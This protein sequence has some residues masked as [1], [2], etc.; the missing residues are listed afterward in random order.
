MARKNFDK[1]LIEAVDDAL[2]SLGES[3]KMAIY[4]H[5]K[6]KFGISKEEIPSRVKEFSEGLEKIFGSGAK[7]I[8]IL[9]MKKLYERIGKPLEWDESKEL[10]F[11]D[12]VETA[13]QCVEKEG[14]VESK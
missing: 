2:S 4:Y 10:T 12:Y 3:A 14:K 8:E 1:L 9:I 13:R 11:A 6:D 7:F 5:V